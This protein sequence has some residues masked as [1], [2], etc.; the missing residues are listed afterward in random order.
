MALR[1]DLHKITVLASSKVRG[2]SRVFGNT[3]DDLEDLKGQRG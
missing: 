3:K 1:C 2:D